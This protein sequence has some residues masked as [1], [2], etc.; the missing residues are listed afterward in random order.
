MDPAARAQE[1][2]RRARHLRG[3]AT[4][5]EQMPVMRLDHW[6]DDDTWR[7]PRP[8]LCRATLQSSQH[9]LHAA[10]DELRL[11]AYRFELEAD[12]LD[13]IARSRI[14]LAG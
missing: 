10:A 8:Q 7:G 11:H 9:Q 1:L 4:T 12:H 6:C 13:A 2:R 3:L 5:I 14:G